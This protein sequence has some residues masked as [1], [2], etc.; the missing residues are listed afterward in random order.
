MHI[1]SCHWQVF[2]PPLVQQLKSL[3]SLPKIQKTIDIPMKCISILESS[4]NQVASFHAAEDAINYWHQKQPSDEIF[5]LDQLQVQSRLLDVYSFLGSKNCIWKRSE[6]TYLPLC[7]EWAWAHF[8]PHEFTLYENLAWLQM[9]S[10]QFSQAHN[11]NISPHLQ[12][13]PCWWS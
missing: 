5:I 12:W 7:W 6:G 11:R 2:R 10:M 13:T 9:F 4:Q 8:N 1:P 3:L